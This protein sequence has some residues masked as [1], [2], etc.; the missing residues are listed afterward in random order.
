MVT[1]TV[2]WG[3]YH[4]EDTPVK[5]QFIR[6]YWLDWPYCHTCIQL[7]LSHP[8]AAFITGKKWRNFEWNSKLVSISIQ[9]GLM[10]RL[11]PLMQGNGS[12]DTIRKG[13]GGP[14][15]LIKSQWHWL[16]YMDS[17]NHYFMCPDSHAQLYTP[18]HYEI[19]C[20]MGQCAVLVFGAGIKQ[21]CSYCVQH[22]TC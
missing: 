6:S 1:F 8:H 19:V 17:S 2:P 15:K 11:Y 20:E 22:C 18:Y 21:A 16:N 4:G 10:H 5:V 7:R 12:G 13:W 9:P 3:R 14:R